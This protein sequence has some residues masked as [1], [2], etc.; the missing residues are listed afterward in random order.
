MKV[1]DRRWWAQA[2]AAGDA[3]QDEN[4]PRP[5]SLKPTYVE[6]LEQKLAE[7]DRQLQEVLAKYRDAARE[8]EDARARM[9]KE[10]AKDAERGRRGFVAELLEVIDNLELALD[11]GRRAAPDDPLLKGVDLVRQQFLAKL[12]GIGVRRLEPLGQPFDPSRHEA[13]SVIP[14]TDAA[15]DHQVC[16]VVR[17]GY[18][19]GD[20]VLRPALVAVARLAT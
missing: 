3:A 11:A 7:N 4:A 9:R 8:F 2:P 10:V 20:D 13:V 18:L 19:I 17:A 5:S 14:V 16:G 1:V 15:Q 12:D 6:E